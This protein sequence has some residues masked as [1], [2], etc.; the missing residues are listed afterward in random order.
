MIARSAVVNVANRFRGRPY[1]L[2]GLG[3][4]GYDCFSFIWCFL[5]ECGVNVPFFYGR[6]SL[7]NYPDIFANNPKASKRV[8]RRFIRSVTRR[9]NRNYI[10]PGDIVIF[11]KTK[12]TGIYL[13]AGNYLAIHG[14]YGVLL[15]PAA[16]I[17][18][19][20][21]DEVRRCRS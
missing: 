12:A 10:L 1:R 7:H 14:D 19:S 3:P 13:G 5:W 20:D 6:L 21:A 4:T 11:S 17:E 9:I 18:Q 15:F 8:L 2:G 16:M